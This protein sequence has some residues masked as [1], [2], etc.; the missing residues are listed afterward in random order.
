MFGEFRRRMTWFCAL[1]TGGI[2]VF[3]TLLCLFVSESA[4]R[5]EQ[6]HTFLNRVDT[7][8]SYMQGENVLTTSLLAKL[9]GRD[10]IYVTI[11]DSGSRMLQ[12]ADADRLGAEEAVREEAAAKGLDIRSPRQKGGGESEYVHFPVR[13]PEGIQYFAAAA[14]FPKAGGDVSAVLLYPLDR[15]RAQI[16]R[17]RW[18]FAGI[19]LMGL[20]AL[21]MFARFFV[22]RLMVPLEQSR[23]DQVQFVAS[24]AHELR[25]P[26]AVMLSNLSAL[27]KA[28]EGEQGRFRDNIR[29]EGLRMSRLV[30]DLLVLA[31]TD[32]HS[33]TMLST[34]T[35]LDTLCLN[36]YERFC[37][38][39]GE[40]GI[41]L[42]VG[43]PDEE[44]PVR[45]CDPGRVEQA[46]SVLLD[47][48][49]SY[50]PPGGT[51][52]LTA[53]RYGGGKVRFSVED[54]GPGVPDS[55]KERVFQRFYRTDRSRGDKEHFGLGLS[56][57]AE[58][59]RLHRGR[60][61]VEDAPGGGAVFHILL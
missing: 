60:I 44:L 56:V 18:L 32:S 4:I 20:A 17:Q 21:F 11:Y 38:P 39:A 46:L 3:M 59:A 28:G 1:A 50:T 19:D 47:N 9:Y 43:L 23:R 36:V 22:R 16:T 45:P 15:L 48:A 27:E 52:K 13:S 49:I 37:G 14:V 12:P 31:N 29:A 24:A 58:I 6:Y 8:C 54:S 57:A 5:D 30:D 61:W 7:L 41:R 34:P 35:E 33:W 53:D 51:V 26:L 10:R 2:F 25:S 40:K 55:E 42:E